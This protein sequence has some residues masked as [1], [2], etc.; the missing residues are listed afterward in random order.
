MIEEKRV[1]HELPFVGNEVTFLHLP[2]QYFTLS[3]LDAREI[4]EPGSV[5]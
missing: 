3:V 2:T 1:F 4:V 5:I